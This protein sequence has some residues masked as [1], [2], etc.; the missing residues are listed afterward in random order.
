MPV[1][2]QS[3]EP[4]TTSQPRTE[5]G[6]RMV[7]PLLPAEASPDLV[8]EARTNTFFSTRQWIKLV[9][10][11]VVGTCVGIAL[12]MAVMHIA[13]DSV[14]QRPAPLSTLG[15]SDLPPGAPPPR[16]GSL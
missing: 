12:G 15:Y 2:N 5:F 6:H 4:D 3:H 10:A 8:E 1:K 16:P 13:R 14:V 7:R 11:V 9:A